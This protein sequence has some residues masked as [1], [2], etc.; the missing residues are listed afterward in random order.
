MFNAIAYPSI[1]ILQKKDPEGS[2]VKTLNWVPGENIDS[3]ASVF[4][5]RCRPMEQKELS[6][7]G[8][9]LESPAVLRL[10][11]KLRKA[12]TPLGEYVKGRLYYGI[13]TGLNEAFVVDRAT[14]DRLIAEHSSSAEVLKPFLRGRDVKRW[15][16]EYADQYLIKFESSE[17]V[18]HP[19]SDKTEIEAEK[20]FKK[21][22]PAIYKWLNHYR[23]KLIK[24]DDQGKF[25]WELRSCAYWEEFERP[26]IVFPDIAKTPEFAYDLSNYF[27]GNTLYLL[28][29]DEKWL[30]GLLNSKLLFWFY[31]NISSLIQGGFVRFIAQYITQMPILTPTDTSQIDLIVSRI[32]ERNNGDDNADTSVLEKEID[33]L[34]YRLYGLTEEEI[35]IVERA[36]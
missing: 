9:K 21:T 3:F 12:G 36:E 29:S 27:L 17:N 13:K 11:E 25:F 19:W 20:V 4:A 14:R 31:K 22:Y 33:W 23:D 34:V 24:R 30:L 2:T 1:I 10:M 16:V 32:I 26:K 8:W 18:S 7:A 15:R 35:R 28:P 5:E 6:G